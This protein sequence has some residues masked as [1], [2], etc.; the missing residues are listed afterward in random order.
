MS[1][2]VASLHVIGSREMGGAERFFLRF[3]D[4]LAAAGS[5]VEA[6][7]RSGSELARLSAHRVPFAQLPMRTVWDP[8]SRWQVTQHARRSDA[9]IVQTYMGRA[10]RLLHL[11]MG[12]GKV[13][14]ARLGGYYK[15]APFAH[16]HGW[17]GNT[18]GLCDWMI[19]QGLPT[20]RVYHI[21][22]FIDAPRAVGADELERLRDRIGAR[23][24][25]WLL[26]HPARFVP[27]KGHDVLLQAFAA[28]PAQIDGRRP[29][30]ILLGDG[31]LAEALRGQARALAIEDRI[32]WAGWQN[33]PAPWM[34]L[35]D[36]VVF[37]SREQETLGNVVLEAWA[38]GKP[39]V[40]TAFRGAREIARAGQDALVVP[41]EDAA[42]LARG[43]EQMLRSA[44]LRAALAAA[45]AARA[46]QD[47]SQAAIVKQY[48]ELYARL[49][50]GG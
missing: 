5:P 8:L 2:G 21:T 11:P 36:V 20:R 38:H 30:L 45:G 18:R 26:L 22:N 49:A 6:A 19:G 34:Q 24:D 17:I 12:R 41:C 39:L 28:L 44:P 33:D 29:R 7:V 32:V 10:T 25:E 50:A 48:Q 15:L 46:A 42:A 43:M 47:F 27:V 14:L 9:P 35:C 13:H 1:A 40:T 23:D 31:A 4:A 37:P 16:A 3:V